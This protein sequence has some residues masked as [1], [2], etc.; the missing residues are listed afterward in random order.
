MV[1]YCNALA[2]I[3]NGNDTDGSLHFLEKPAKYGPLRLDFDLKLPPTDS[4]ERVYTKRIVM[5]I[6]EICIEAIGEVAD[7]DLEDGETEEE[8]NKKYRCV[9]LEKSAPRLDSGVIKDGFHIHFPFFVVDAWTQEKIQKMVITEMIERRVWTKTPFSKCARDVLD[10]GV[11]HKTWLMYGSS[12]GEG[13]EPYM[14]TK[15]YDEYSNSVTIK[16]FFEDELEG[17]K[18]GAKYYLPRFL[19]INGF[20]EPSRLKR[21]VIKEREHLVSSSRRFGNK[22][23]QK[24]KHQ[25]EAD[26]ELIKRGK[27]M[28]ML[29]SDRAYHYDQWMEV[30]RMLF[31][32]AQ[33]TEAGL[34]LWI[35]FSKRDMTK[36]SDGEC[37]ELWAKMKPNGYTIATLFWMA[38]NDSPDKYYEWRN[39]GLEACI[40]KCME[41]PKPTEHD[42]AMVFVQ[43]FGD[44]F[45]CAN[46][47]SKEWYE[48]YDHRWHEMDNG[49]QMR[50]MFP[51]DLYKIFERFKETQE[52][53]VKDAESEKKAWLKESI[54]RTRAIMSSLK[55]SAFQR[56][57][58]EQCEFE[59]YN[60]DFL[61]KKDE[62]VHLWV[63]ENGVLDLKEGIFRDGKPDDYCTFSCGINY[64]EFTD[65]DEDVKTLNDFF[66]KVFVNEN[67]RN[68]FLDN[69]CS[70]MEGGNPNKNFIIGTGCGSNGKS[71]TYLLLRAFSGDYCWTFPRELFIIGKGNSSGAARP[72]LSAIRGR[73]LAL[74]NELAKTDVVNIGV[75]KELTGNDVFFG[76]AL[77]KEASEVKPQFKLFMHCNEPP[78]IPAHDDASW[79]RSSF[80]D[81]EAIFV[82]PRKLKKLPVPKEKSKQYK[83][84][85]FH[86]DLSLADKMP[87][88]AVAF[89]WM[90]FNRFKIYKQRG[91]VTPH[92]VTHANK[93]QRNKNDFYGLFMKER[94]EKTKDKS[95]FIKFTELADDFIDWYNDAFPQAREKFS[96]P[97]FETEISKKMGNPQKKG[98]CKGWY[99]YR[100]LPEEGEGYE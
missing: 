92:E 86:A 89:L 3:L 91:L 39:S 22:I 61:K 5:K 59:L 95:D 72:E 67:L 65:D 6:I 88:L 40:K 56:K 43:K 69:V 37:E 97:S 82:L 93:I 13:F 66:G 96:K 77:Y 54:S 52:G 41:E 19:S 24:S 26:L 79:D 46:S 50:K 53:L 16:E 32:V 34:E 80:L 74:V 98:N 11:F 17:K 31:S 60:K 76:R 75:L 25:V 85:R 83:L 20:D 49:V 63:C 58:L 15:F 81:F 23:S 71:V 10:T 78:K 27:L 48:F 47:R 29:S 87:R 36:Y 64:V 51:T 21:D 33:G 94:V 100:L 55:T 45:L 68:Y 90:M 99:G 38:K 9:L 7:D 57:V 1:Y 44:R 2:A 28:N 4:L 35:E 14:A 12:K 70:I 73:R 30:G 62:N 8:A 42:V 18:M 84:K